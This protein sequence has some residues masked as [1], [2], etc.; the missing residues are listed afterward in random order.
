[1]TDPVSSDPK[2][3]PPPLEIPGGDGV[4]LSDLERL[5]RFTWRWFLRFLVLV[6]WTIAAVAVE[7]LVYRWE[8]AVVFRRGRPSPLPYI[9][10]AVGVSIAFVLVHIPRAQA[11]CLECSEAKDRFECENEAR[12]TI[13]QIIGGALV[14]CGLYST[15][16]SYNLQR[17]GQVT[18]S[19]AKAIDQLG[20]MKT[21]QNGK[22]RINLELRIGGIYALEKIA[23]DSPLSQSKI[24]EVL[25]AYVR[26]NSPLPNEKAQPRSC[27]VDSPSGAIARPLPAPADIQA[28]LTVIGRRDSGDDQGRFLDLTQTDLRCLS[29]HG[30]QLRG[31]HLSWSD[32]GG[33]DLSDA[34]LRDADLRSS[35]LSGALGL[36]QGQLKSAIGDGNTKLP[37]GL[38]RPNSWDR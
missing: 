15:L 18:D 24:V 1:M 30:A 34:D 19:F 17:T 37:S 23:H 11:K 16:Q 21:G 13:A 26:D 28:S 9:F 3:I 12:R 27:W 32:F 8:M 7:T 29:L 33:A 20:A 4:S 10:A 35:D 36:T 14:L 38:S 22:P 2:P 5:G 6:G 31:A 25:T